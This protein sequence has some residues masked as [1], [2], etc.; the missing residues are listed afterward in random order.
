ML[1]KLDGD[2]RGGA[3]LSMRAITG[4]PIKFIGEGEKIDNLSE[5]YPERMAGRILDMGDVVTMVEQVADKINEK[6]AMKTAK[7][8][9]DGKFDFNDFLDQMNMIKKLGPLDGILGMLPGM[10][11]LKKQIPTDLFDNK[12][13]KRMEAI[14][15]SMT[16]DERA[17]PVLIKGTRR[18]RIA[19]GSGNTVLEVNKLLKNFANMKKMMG[20]KGKMKQMMEALGGGMPGMGDA[21]GGDMSDMDL[22]KMLGG[23]GGA[24]GGMPKGGP[25]MEQLAEMQDM[26]RKGKKGKGGFPF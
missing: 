5:F 18:K 4:K 9:Q 13:M 11:N 10:R 17:R 20:N 14:V 12:R 15:L 23:A 21:A 8:M 6:D 22:E 1:T 16:P 3:A 26:M 25:S 7:R 19:A 24:G 2:A